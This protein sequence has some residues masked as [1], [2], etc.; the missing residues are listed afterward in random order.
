LLKVKSIDFLEYSNYY[1]GN[2]T[3]LLHLVFS[4]GPTPYM[5]NLKKD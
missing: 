1:Y 5:V 4:P 2:F 3:Q